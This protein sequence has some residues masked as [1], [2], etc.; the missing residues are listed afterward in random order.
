MASTLKTTI[1]GPFRDACPYASDGT[2]SISDQEDE[3]YQHLRDVAH[4]TR[5]SKPCQNCGK[6]CQGEAK[7]KVPQPTADIKN[8]KSIIVFC[9]DK[10]RKDY[11]NKLG[12]SV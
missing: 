6:K 5:Y 2:K 12:V 10:C 7:G 8:P 3:W 11:M 1:E 9:D 4:M